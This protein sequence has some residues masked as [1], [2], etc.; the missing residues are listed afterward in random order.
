M[1]IQSN[2][3][4]WDE[5]RAGRA[6]EAG[7]NIYWLYSGIQKND[8]KL[9]AI[10]LKAIIKHEQWRKWRWIGQE[11]ECKS[12][13]ECLLRKPPNGVGADIN[14]LKRLVYDDKEA[15]DKLDE[16][17]RN[18][19]GSN[20]YTFN[21]EQERYNIPL[22]KAPGGT[23]IEKALRRLRADSRPIAKELHG[24]VLA[25]ELSA[26]RAAILAGYR[27]QMTILEQIQK[28]WKKLDADGRKA[29]LEW[30]SRQCATCGREGHW[31][32]ENRHDVPQ[33]SYCDACMNEHAL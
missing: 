19:H 22:Q 24:K 33:G 27:R 32:T 18:P 20:Q 1:A 3:D 10:T 25:G 16:A 17:L 26:H 5:I 21:V 4:P 6:D 2:L 13:R 9:I 28:L 7:A 12:L 14:I 30:T 15:L 29:H 31:I 11:F 8:L 23:S